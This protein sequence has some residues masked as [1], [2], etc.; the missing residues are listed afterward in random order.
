MIALL[1]D[2]TKSKIY[3]FYVSIQYKMNDK[4]IKSSYYDPEYG[5]FSATKLY[6]KLKDKGVTLNEVKDFIKKQEVGQ[7]GH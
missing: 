2:I 3:K 5:L 7:D 6:Q 1:M 4:L